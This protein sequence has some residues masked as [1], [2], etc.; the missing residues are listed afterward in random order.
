MKHKRKPSDNYLPTKRDWRVLLLLFV[1]GMSSWV[2]FYL[3][4]MLIS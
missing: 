1:I 3:A 2:V 4:A